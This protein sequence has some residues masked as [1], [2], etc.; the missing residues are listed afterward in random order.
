[1]S[2][3]LHSASLAHL[4][5]QLFWLEGNGEGLAPPLLINKL[6]INSPLNSPLNWVLALAMGGAGSRDSNLDLTRLAAIALY[7]KWLLPPS[8]QTR[9]ADRRM[10]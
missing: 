7:R 9:W 1:M 5:R 6:R 3:G 8:L 2:L 4:H 10:G